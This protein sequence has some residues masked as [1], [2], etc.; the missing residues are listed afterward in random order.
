MHPL[1]ALIVDISLQLQ[2]TMRIYERNTQAASGDAFADKIAKGSAQFMQQTT[3]MFKQVSFLNCS[4]SKTTPASTDIMVDQVIHVPSASMTVQ[5]D[6]TEVSISDAPPQFAC[7]GALGEWLKDLE[8]RKAARQ[9]AEAVR[10]LR[11]ATSQQQQQWLR[12]QQQQQQHV[13][14]SVRATASD[15]GWETRTMEP[16][17]E[18]EGILF[19]RSDTAVEIIFP[20]VYSKSLF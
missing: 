7:E 16:S 9:K 18:H 4:A 20:P 17:V 6:M 1:K 15:P 5:S 8:A 13:T 11:K 19:T 10:N 14:Q 2:E 12:Q 3:Q